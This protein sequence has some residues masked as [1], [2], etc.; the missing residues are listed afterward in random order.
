MTVTTVRLGTRMRFSTE[1]TQQSKISGLAPEASP[2]G[3]DD[4]ACPTAWA[5]VDKA[6]KAYDKAVAQARYRRR[7]T[8]RL[9]RHVRR[10][11]RRLA[12]QTRRS[13]S[14]TCYE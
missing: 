8:R 10:S 2:L 7:T 5:A 12:R 11:T 14:E 1:I 13:L 6:R 9:Y 4:L 3:I